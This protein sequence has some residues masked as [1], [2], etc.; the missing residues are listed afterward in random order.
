MA[1]KLN[2]K[3]LL[4]CQYEYTKL[5]KCRRFCTNWENVGLTC[6][7]TLRFCANCENVGL[8]CNLTFNRQMFVERVFVFLQNFSTLFSL[9]VPKS[10]C[11]EQSYFLEALIHVGLAS[12]L[13]IL[14]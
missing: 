13:L 10:Y 11:L 4:N 12:Y 8:T 3:K 7:L 14:L 5:E 1:D 2:V 6:N 9:Y